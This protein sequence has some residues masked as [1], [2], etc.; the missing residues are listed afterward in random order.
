MKLFSHLKYVILVQWLASYATHLMVRERYRRKGTL[1][2][3][4]KTGG[5]SVKGP[6]IHNQ[7]RQYRRPMAS[8][9]YS[10]NLGFLFI[11]Q[12]ITNQ[13]VHKKSF[14]PNSIFFVAQKNRIIRFLTVR[15]QCIEHAFLKISDFSNKP[16]AQKQ[17]SKFPVQ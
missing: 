17:S 1:S 12:K 3:L 2:G 5:C 13:C 8:R 11:K 10:T 6:K 9:E 4:P 14:H 16:E 15:Q 7:V